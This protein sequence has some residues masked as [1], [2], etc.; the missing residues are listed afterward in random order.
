LIVI[1][2]TREN[3]GNQALD[4]LDNFNFVKKSEKV[5]F[6]CLS[7]GQKMAARQ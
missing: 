5:D 6:A 1:T 3:P 2:P 7:V 4:K